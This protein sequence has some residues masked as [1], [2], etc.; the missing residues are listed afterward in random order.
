[1]KLH[2]YT[3][4]LLVAAGAVAQ[5]A[6]QN[7][8]EINNRPWLVIS[9]TLHATTN[10]NYNWA[11]VVPA[12]YWNAGPG[13]AKGHVSSFWIPREIQTVREDRKVGGT[14]IGIRPS[15]ATTAFPYSGYVP[16]TSV[17][18]TKSL[19]GSGGWFNG[20]DRTA[21]LAAKA[22]VTI[23]QRPHTFAAMGN[24]VVASTL[25]TPATIPAGKNSEDIAFAW[26]WNGGEQRDLAATATKP[27]QSMFSTFSCGIHT[28]TV[29]DEHASATS[30][31]ARSVDFGTTWGGMSLADQVVLHQV[32]R[33][34]YRRDVRLEPRV[35]STSLGVGQNDLAAA[36]DTFG[37]EIKAG[38]K[39]ANNN[40]GLLF[41]F[42]PVFPAKF[43]LMGLT[44]ELNPAD[45]TLGSLNALNGTVDAQGLFSTALIPFPILGP[46]A[47]KA[48]FG[49][50]GVCMNLGGGPVKLTSTGSVWS[51]VSR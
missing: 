29:C 13:V 11:S 40:A 10:A 35:V 27:S 45:A 18:P 34:G 24:Y 36:A 32:A 19:A 49:V 8:L 39:R 16:E 51:K 28:P 14:Y 12:A 17:T 46:T 9:A 1:M 2:I 25:S 22:F 23:P 26:K 5:G 38:A 44:L 6:D 20:E 15:A 48:T 31:V 7:R 4:A 37:W 47:L 3:S 43:N 41:N 30:M 33:V 42:G 50:E 21:D